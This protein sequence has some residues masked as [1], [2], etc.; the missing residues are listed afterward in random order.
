MGF[1]A[2]GLF[3]IEQNKYDSNEIKPRRNLFIFCN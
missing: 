2:D 3:G 1:T